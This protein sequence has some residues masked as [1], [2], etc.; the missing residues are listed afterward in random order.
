[1][2]LNLNN[3]SSELLKDTKY[4][5][6]KCTVQSSGITFQNVTLESVNKSYQIAHSS[7][8]IR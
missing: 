6:D 7:M 2:C 8:M 5:D 4:N 1:M 3:K